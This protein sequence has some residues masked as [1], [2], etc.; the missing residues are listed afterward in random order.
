[1]AKKVKEVKEKK[2]KKVKERVPFEVS[3]EEK[4]LQDE[5]VLIAQRNP[6]A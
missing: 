2:Q 6:R 3:Q 4:R 1:M 5:K